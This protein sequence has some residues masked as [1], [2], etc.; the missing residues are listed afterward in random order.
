MTIRSAMAWLLVLFSVLPATAQPVVEITAPWKNARF[1]QCAAIPLAASTT[2][3]DEDIRNCYFYQN[4]QSLKGLRKPPFEYEWQN[5]PPGMYELT[6]RI[7]D[8]NN[9]N[10]FSD[11][12][13]IFVGEVE[14]GDMIRNGEFACS[15]WPW[16]LHLS[17]GNATYEI[18]P[19]AWLS[20]DTTAAVVEISNSGTETWSVQ[21]MQRVPLKS[22]HTYEI[23]FIADALD[24]KTIQIN[25]QQDVDP[26]T[27]YWSADLTI[28]RVTEF[29]P[30]TFECSVDDPTAN[31]K[32][33]LAY[34]DVTVYLDAVRVIDM[35]WTGVEAEED[36]AERGMNRDF[37]LLQNYPNPFNA[38][39]T[40]RYRAAAAGQVTISLYTVQGRLIRTLQRGHVVPGDHTLN[41]SADGLAT[42]V[43]LIGLR[44]GRFSE[45]KKCL[46]L[47]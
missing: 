12:V 29:G 43:Y 47:K 31:F 10:H 1:Q 28:D 42:G 15:K 39:T 19:Q 6:A 7:R 38:S 25:F 2:M 24:E 46:L 20:Y 35:M 21:L 18:E 34:D 45:V 8:M 9:V 22:G 41:W 13:T 33:I 4:G 44:A 30:F 37:Q 14:E 36:A 26:Y 17:G 5:V 3:P 27:V 40:L 32:F 11:P 16:T 23:S